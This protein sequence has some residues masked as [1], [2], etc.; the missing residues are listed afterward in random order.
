[1]NPHI[2]SFPIQPKKGETQHLRFLIH[3]EIPYPDTEGFG[4]RLQWRNTG[5]LLPKHGAPATGLEKT[6][7]C[8]LLPP[9]GTPP[10]NFNR[11]HLAGYENNP[12]TLVIR[13][14]NLGE[15]TVTISETWQSSR[16]CGFENPTPF[17]EKVFSQW[18]YPTLREHIE[19][20]KKSLYEEATQKVEQNFLEKL[21]QL[22]RSL[23]ELRQESQ[24]ALGFLKS[25][26]PQ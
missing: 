3:Q 15:V 8:L 12:G 2:F 14:K 23:E 24:K 18:I 16:V 11:T 20:N 13:G 17:E 7:R 19:E 22:Q 9:S 4:G 6:Y 5:G 1:M 10:P 25:K 26:T 21:E